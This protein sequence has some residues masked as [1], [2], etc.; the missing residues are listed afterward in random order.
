MILF[1]S[2]ILKTSCIVERAISVEHTATKFS[3]APSCLRALTSQLA[4]FPL[5]LFP[6]TMN[7]LPYRSDSLDIEISPFVFTNILSQTEV[8]VVQSP[9]RS[10]AYAGMLKSM[11]CMQAEKER[12]FIPE[13]QTTFPAWPIMVGRFRIT[14]ASL[15]APLTAKIASINSEVVG[16]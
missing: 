16:C 6:S 14:K 12:A 3:I 4:I 2:S 9:F 5:I 13:E 7:P 10:N 1:S 15:S 11:Q 8:S